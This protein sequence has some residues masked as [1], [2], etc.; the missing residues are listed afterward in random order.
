MMSGGVCPKASCS[1]PSTN[2]DEP[3][4]FE[5]LRKRLRR[6]NFRISRTLIL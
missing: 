6:L 3:E 4:Y 2:D 1:M 5:A